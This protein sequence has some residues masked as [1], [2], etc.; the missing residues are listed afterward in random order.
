MKTMTNDNENKNMDDGKSTWDSMAAVHGSSILAVNNDT[1]MEVL[2]H[3]ALER[4]LKG[5]VHGNALRVLDLGCGNGRT[6]MFLARTFPGWQFTGVDYSGEMINVAMAT[7]D[8]DPKPLPN[9]DFVVMDAVT[10]DLS[11]LGAFDVVITKR[12][13]VNMKGKTKHDVFNKIATIVK[14][15]GWYIACECFIEPLDRINAMRKVL[16]FPEIVVRSFNEYLHENEFMANDDEDLY[17]AMTIDFQSLYY[18]VSRVFNARD[19]VYDAAINKDAVKL[20]LSYAP[21]AIHGF[22]PEKILVF[23]KELETDHHVTTDRGDD[24]IDPFGFDKRK[25]DDLH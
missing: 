23:K 8:K 16:G 9:V 1:N 2:E 7:N 15:G 12:L 5:N 24:Y 14:P 21:I 10:G 13:L 4:F 11:R 3:D 6:T 17:L 20:L 22:S 25:F 19:P 18:L